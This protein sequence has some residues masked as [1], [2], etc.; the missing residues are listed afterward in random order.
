MSITRSNVEQALLSRCAGIMKVVG[1][2][3]LTM[4]GTNPDLNDPIY[5]ALAFQGIFASNMALVVDADLVNVADWRISQLIDAAEMRLLENLWGNWPYYSQKISQ[6]Q[7][8]AQQLAD[9]I[10]VRVKD[11]EER[12]RH[13]YGPGTAGVAV[14]RIA[15]GRCIPGDRRGYGRYGYGYGGLNW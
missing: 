9:R 5:R 6:G 1:L 2:N 4:D 12:L 10:Q 13:P 3:A 11:L 8:E 14:G 15:T 7:Q